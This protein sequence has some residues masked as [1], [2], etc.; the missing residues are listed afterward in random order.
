MVLPRMSK[1]I[2]GEI[3]L[4]H[5]L[6]SRRLPEVSSFSVSKSIVQTWKQAK[7]KCRFGGPS[8]L[9]ACKT[10][11]FHSVPPNFP[12]ETALFNPCLHVVQSYISD[13]GNQAPPTAG[14]HND[15]ILPV[16][17]LED[18]NGPT[19]QTSFS[20][21]CNLLKTIEPIWHKQL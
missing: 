14:S 20:S 3:W 7:T 10:G 19:G 1:A 15:L 18:G 2:Y 4:S 13:L 16:Q 17:C 6:S 5:Q 11:P 21:I 9:F 12:C 8:R